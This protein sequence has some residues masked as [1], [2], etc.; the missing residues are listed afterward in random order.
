MLPS[1]NS[2][3][4]FVRP[5]LL[6]VLSVKRD[7]P[8]LILTTVPLDA[9]SSFELW[10]P[11]WTPKGTILLPF[12]GELLQKDGLRVTKVLAKMVWLMGAICLAEDDWEVAD[13]TPLYDWQKVIDF[14]IR[15]GHCSAPIVTKVVF[16]PHSFVS[17]ENPKVKATGV[18]PPLAWEISPPHWSIMFDSLIPVHGGFQVK[19][20]GDLISVDIW[21]GKPMRREL[22]GGRF[23]VQFSDRNTNK[24]L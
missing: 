16:H 1:Q 19:P 21:M 13:R 23:Y 5:E 18:I 4:A 6:K 9:K 3:S 11:K 14:V 7:T 20:T 22:Q 17:I 24:R 2:S 15:E 12:E 8:N 10:T